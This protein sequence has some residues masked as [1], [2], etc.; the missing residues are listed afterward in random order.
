MALTWRHV[1]R[2]P[3]DEVGIRTM[4]RLF[5]AAS[6]LTMVS[7]GA[8]A[9]DQV[10]TIPAKTAYSWSGLYAGVYAG[11]AWANTS[12]TSGVPGE[13]FF[14]NNDFDSF[15]TDDSGFLGGVIFGYN[16]QFGNIVAGVE[17]EIGYLGA[18]PSAVA[19]DENDGD[20]VAAD[21]GPYGVAA[22]RLG[23]AFDRMLI[24][25]KAGLAVAHIENTGADLDG[26]AFDPDFSYVTDDTHL[27]LALGGGLEFAFAGG[28][29]ARVEYLH[30][31]FE[32]FTAEDAGGRTYEV[33]NSVNTV[34]IGLSY[35]F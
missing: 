24:Y 4:A 14:D 28:W 31:Q 9:A 27:G 5:L 32:D 29:S 16:H 34:K 10:E 11:G 21:Y 3:P 13:G 20:L 22:A 6:C 7:F 2:R 25:G 26:T 18:D 8:L 1:Y 12:V 30:M 33:E 15:S 17:A 23:F 19:P 35:R